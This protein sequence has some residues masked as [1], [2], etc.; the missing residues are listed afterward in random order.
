MIA[1]LNIVFQHPRPP[2]HLVVAPIT[3][4]AGIY[5]STMLANG[6]THI[7][8]T[9][10]DPLS[11]LQAIERYKITTLFLPPTII[12][13][14]L[15][16]PRVRDFDYSSLVSFVYGSAP[17]SVEKLR[18]AMDIFGPVFVQ[19][20]GQSEALMMCTYLS[21][22]DHVEA[23]SDPGLEHRL[24]SVGREGPLVRLAIMDEDGAILPADQRG[25]IVVRSDIVMDGYVDNPEATAQASAFG[26]HHT[27]DIGY[28]DKDGFV[29]IVDRKKDMII[30][31]GFNVFP[32]EVEQAVLSHPSV[33]D[34]AVVGI[35]D[36][37]W[38]EAV[39][40][41]VELKAGASLDEAAIIEHCKNRLGSMKAPKTVKAVAS[42]PRSPVGKVLRRE[43]RAPYWLNHSRAV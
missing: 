31:G 39:L 17:M 1:E 27:G 41:A 2:I 40:A 16:H 32:A 26:W 42:L 36:P 12:Y 34:C 8:L 10:P 35:P 9:N 24:A 11:I 22:R 5:A 13:M 14:L 3:H 43:V 4:A 15:A 18:E 33:L 25:E 30:T 38:G 6:G 37:K 23:L 29:Y 21:A 20:Y 28:K 7:L 19:G